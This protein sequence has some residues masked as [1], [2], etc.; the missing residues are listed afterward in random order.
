MRVCAADLLRSSL[1]L[2]RHGVRILR[3]QKTNPPRNRRCGI[4][5]SMSPCRDY[6]W[7]AVAPEEC[8]ATDVYLVRYRLYRSARDKRRARYF[9][10]RSTRPSDHGSKNAGQRRSGQKS[11]G[12]SRSSYVARR[13]EI[14]NGITRRLRVVARQSAAVRSLF[15]LS[16][17]AVLA[18]FRQD[19]PPADSRM[20]FG[21]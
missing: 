1:Q 14:R 17:R 10:S 7:R 8:T 4:D 19:R 15:P 20:D 9:E 11:L 3:R 13:S 16:R 6:G 21:R 2:L 12:E 18:D 5:V